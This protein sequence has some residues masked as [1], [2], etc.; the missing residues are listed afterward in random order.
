[1]D[2]E[3]E[4]NRGIRN[5]KFAA[6]FSDTVK[7]IENDFLYVNRGVRYYGRVLR[8]GPKRPRR[9]QFGLA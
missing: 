9:C 2:H 7:D 8:I 5:P 3:E 1:M 4:I 6:G